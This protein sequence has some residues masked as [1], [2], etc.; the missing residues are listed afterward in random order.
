[1]FYKNFFYNFKNKKFNNAILYNFDSPPVKLNVI[2][3]NSFVRRQGNIEKYHYY[4]RRNTII[5]IHSFK[6]P[7]K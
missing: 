4:F 1:M 5:N 2:R 6:I 3:I 7:N